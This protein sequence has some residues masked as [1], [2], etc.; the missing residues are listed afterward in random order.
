MKALLF[1]LLISLLATSAFAADPPPRVFDEGVLQGVYF[2]LDF[3]GTGVTATKSG[4]TATVTV[5]APATPTLQQVTTAGKTTT[6]GI[7]ITASDLK[8]DDTVSAIFGTDSDWDMA[9]NSGTTLTLSPV[10]SNSVFDVNGRITVDVNSPVGGDTALN[11][12]NLYNTVSGSSKPG[13]TAQKANL[14]WIS[15]DSSSSTQRGFQFA[16]NIDGGTHPAIYGGDFGVSLGSASVTNITEFR[17]VSTAMSLGAGAALTVTDAINF[18]AATPLPQASSI[19]TNYRGAFFDTL[20]AFTGTVTNATHIE[21]EDLGSY[22]STSNK[23]LFIT[24]AGEIFWRDAN[25]RMGSSATNQLDIFVPTTL[26]ITQTTAGSNFII[27]NTNAGATGIVE[28][29]YQ[30][31][32]SPAAADVLRRQ[33]IFGNDSGGNKTEYGRI[34]VSIPNTPTGV[35][36]GQERGQMDLQVMNNGTL[37]SM[38]QLIGQQNAGGGDLKQIVFSADLK[39]NAG[40]DYYVFGNEPA[41]LYDAGTTGNPTRTLAGIWFQ[42]TVGEEGFITTFSDGTIS[43]RLDPVTGNVYFYYD[44]S[45]IDMQTAGHDMLIGG[46]RAGDMTY[47]NV[48]NTPFH[49]F[50]GTATSRVILP[51]PSS[52]KVGGV[53]FDHFADVGNVG[54]GDDDLY[55]DTLVAGTLN[56]DGAKVFATYGGIFAG[57]AASTQRFRIYFGGTQIYD[58]GALSI[59]VATNNWTANVMCARES[60]S[61]VRCTTWVN[62]DFATLFPYSTYTRV[63]GLTLSNTQVVKITGETAGVGAANDQIVAKEGTLKFYPAA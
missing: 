53:I 44:D 32:A 13:L 18:Y 14:S 36:N 1:S 20:G 26:K 38:I 54:T 63:T 28:E 34:D 59:G 4:T 50:L 22:A 23:E 49:Q 57:A 11:I 17:A 62:T 48:T 45:G 30:N 3:V 25:T 56:A 10:V 46:N 61:V 6:Q 41:F 37:S 58:T 8:L 29:F 5:N 47:G 33:S 9:V 31:S 7:T 16:L 35:T 12:S 21:I 60:S 43:N 39:F 51:A 19:I 24:A 40:A 27:E 52:A 15:T 2:N 55:S 42:T